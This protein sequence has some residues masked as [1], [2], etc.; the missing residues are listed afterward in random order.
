MTAL[1]AI[2]LLVYAG[3]AGYGIYY[4][5]GVRADR[6]K[7]TATALAATSRADLLTQQLET[8]ALQ[9]AASAKARDAQTDLINRQRVQFK[10]MQERLTSAEATLAKQA[11]P[12]VVGAHAVDVLTS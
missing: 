6:N 9:Q 7:L 11:D 4:L 10:D 8:A 1:D 5:N 3:L 2:V 12:A